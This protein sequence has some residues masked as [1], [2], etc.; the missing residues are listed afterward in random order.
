MSSSP[1]IN[2]GG[3]VNP[4][5][6]AIPGRADG[7]VVKNSSNSAVAITAGKVEANAKLYAL[8]AD[9]T[10][11]MTSLAAGFGRHY[12][13]IDDSE[14]SAP[15]AA[16]IDS[17]TAPTKSVP[18]NGWYNGDD[19]C[20]GFCYSPAGGATIIQFGIVAQSGQKIR[21]FFSVVSS[22]EFNLA[23]NMSPNGAWQ[24]P[25][26]RESSAILPPMAEELF[27]WM[28]NSDVGGQ[29]TIA[30]VQSELAAGTFT[31]GHFY[32]AIN[33]QGADQGWIPL[34]ASKNIKIS[35]EADDDN[36]LFAYINGVGYSR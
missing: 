6:L 7:F 36:A 23:T 32:V 25:N 18:K 14:S 4:A 13:Y 35:G 34:G 16:I 9:T 2:S 12:I 8:A 28:Q 26:V 20:I 1:I 10:H 11:A 33:V 29:V 17:T 30:A 19:R 21:M 3:G 5:N 24:T 27:V 22:V 15:V 31:N